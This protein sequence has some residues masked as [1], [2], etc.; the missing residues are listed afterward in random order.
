MP[1]SARNG[2]RSPVEWQAIVERQVKSDLPA[3][4]FCRQ[5]KI[6]YTSFLFGRR[7]ARL[8]SKPASFVDVTPKASSWDVE[9]ALPSGIVL[10]FRG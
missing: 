4:E 6:P 9:V 10:R 5:E 2:R 7:L 1:R 8:A 3:P